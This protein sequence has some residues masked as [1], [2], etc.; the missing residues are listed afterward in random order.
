MAR[1]QGMKLLS[2]FL[3]YI[4]LILFGLSSKSSRQF[5]LWER[6]LSYLNEALPSTDH[7]DLVG[8][9][10]IGPAYYI[11]FY[12]LSRC[13]KVQWSSLKITSVCTASLC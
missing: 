7:E 13:L 5:S 4:L 3:T 2:I 6:N 12:N 11:Y 1:V 9:K 10:F 8:L